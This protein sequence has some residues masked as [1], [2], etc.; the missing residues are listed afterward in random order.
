MLCV[1]KCGRLGLWGGLVLAAF[2][3]CGDSSDAF[4]GEDGGFDGGDMDCEDVEIPGCDNVEFVCRESC[5]CVCVDDTG[6]ATD[7]GEVTTGDVTTTSEDTSTTA[8]DGL[9]SGSSTADATSAATSTGEDSTSGDTTGSGT[10][11][12]PLGDCV[13]VDVWASCDAY[14]A[15]IMESCSPGGCD[16]GTVHYYNS[17]A[18]CDR[19]VDADVS[20]Q[21]CSDPLET[22][23][24]VSFARCCCQ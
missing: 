14:C 7:D 24:G 10:S 21:A 16:G 2:F 17:G 22:S 9:D 5:G 8:D 3:G 11:G 12:S 13:S 1:M 15:A 18:D 20:D 6:G 23:G 4:F 19:Q